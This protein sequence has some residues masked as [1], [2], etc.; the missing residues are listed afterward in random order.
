MIRPDR[1]SGSI[2]VVFSLLAT[3]A[4][5]WDDPWLFLMLLVVA[6]SGGLVA[7]LIRNNI[8]PRYFEVDPH[9]EFFISSA[10]DPGERIIVKPVEDK[11]GRRSYMVKRSWW[12]HASSDLQ[13]GI[14]EA[15]ANHM[16]DEDYIN[17]IAHLI[18]PIPREVL[19]EF[20]Y[21]E[22]RRCPEVNRATGD[23][24]QQLAAIFAFIGPEAAYKKF[25]DLAEAHNKSVE[26]AKLQ[27][28]VEQD[29]T[30]PA[31]D[32]ET[33]AGDAGRE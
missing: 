10:D 31:R 19:D 2:L 27:E 28:E 26:A 20:M 4:I 6:F 9:V 22:F 12:E 25:Y 18:K 33:H 17:K 16:N 13:P 8:P 5:G 29:A 11:K 15:V 1:L 14:T 32:S 3:G 21:S 23:A 30:T 24:L 7:H